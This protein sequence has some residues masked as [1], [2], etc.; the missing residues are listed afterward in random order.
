MLRQAI[1]SRSANV[2]RPPA[3]GG[4]RGLAGG[5]GASLFMA[6]AAGFQALLGRLTAQDDV[7]VGTAVANRDRVEL[8]GLIGFFVNTLVL[9]GD[10]SGAP[11]FRELLG[12]VR[13]TALAAYLH[14]DVPFEK[15]VEEL[16]PERNLSYPPLFQVMLALQNA[17]AGSLEIETLRLRPLNV[18]GAVAKFDLTV[19][20]G[21]SRGGLV[22]GAEYATDLFD[23]TTVD[24]LAAGFE[25]LLT[26]AVGDADR[27]VADLP[28]L[29]PA[30]LHQLI[31]QLPPAAHAAVPGPPVLALFEGWADRTP[32]AIA[33]FAAGEAVT[34]AE[35]DRRANRLA[36][37][38]VRLG[39]MMETRVGLCVERS[40]EMLIAV[41]GILKAGG[42]YVPLDP[43][44]PRERL[45][46]LMEDARVAV[47]ITQE[48]LLDRL[49]AGTGVATVLL[50]AG[51]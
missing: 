45:A 1:S 41:L 4:L 36:H 37:R 44:Y 17:P 26:A 40:V 47:L 9:R 29:S 39:V 16:A 6:L 48:R 34:W 46:F 10:L 31:E 19:S 5:R 8:E 49:P 15:L 25:R 11:S 27:C 38:L 32:D 12:R 14:Q 51:G 33:A 2:S 30:E 24:R 28:L 42:A 22:G 23:A 7:L 20:F 43:A 3:A 50:D 18:E 35:L 13:E 21:E